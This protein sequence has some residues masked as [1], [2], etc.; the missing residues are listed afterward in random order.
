MGGVG[1]K[2]LGVYHSVFDELDFVSEHRARFLGLRRAFE[3]EMSRCGVATTHEHDER[4]LQYEQAATG[5]AA[6]RCAVLL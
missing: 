4:I 2:G 5:P 3:V 1:P 6:S